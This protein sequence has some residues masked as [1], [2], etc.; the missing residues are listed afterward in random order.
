MPNGYS[1]K[2]V[3]LDRDGTIIVDK[4][5]LKTPEEV[6]LIPGTIEAIKLFNTLKLPVVVISN[7]SGVARGYFS[8]ED[9]QRV[10]HRLQSLLQSKGARVDKIYYCPHYPEG[11]VEKYSVECD[12]RKPKPGMILKACRDLGIT[13]DGSFV[14]GDKDSDIILGRAV[15]ALTILVLTGKGE[16]AV[17]KPDFVAKNILEAAHWI[18]GRLKYERS[19]IL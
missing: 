9:V 7:Q 14:V 3:F 5:Y 2:A 12:C 6:E 1:S 11:V 19:T 15:N 16:T 10:N 4:D 13:P 17:Q 18:E 8:E